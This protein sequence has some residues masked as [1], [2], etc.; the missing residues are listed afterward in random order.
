VRQLF[1]FPEEAS[2]LFVTGTSMANLM[3]VLVARHAKLGPDARRSGIGPAGSQLRAYASRAAHGCV[4]QAM[5]LAG[6]GI[7]SLRLIPVDANF[8]MDIPAL[9]A[10]IARDRQEGHAPFLVVG[11]AGTVDAGAVD[12]LDAIAALCRE[13][14]CGSMWMAPMGLWGCCLPRLRRAS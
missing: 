4:S 3:A 8:R 5:D 9:R 12:D 6:I 11:S 10:A 7:D 13:K 1:D 2:G 14:K